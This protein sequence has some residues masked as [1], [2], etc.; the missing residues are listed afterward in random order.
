MTNENGARGAPPL[1]SAFRV[2]DIRMSQLFSIG[3]VVPFVVRMAPIALLLASDWRADMVVWLFW[4]ETA[5][6]GVGNAVRMVIGPADRIQSRSARAGLAVIFLVCYEGFVALTGLFCSGLFPGVTGLQIVNG[7]VLV[8]LGYA[9]SLA[10]VLLYG[11]EDRPIPISLLVVGPVTRAGA[12]YAIAFMG[13]MLAM[14]LGSPLPALIPLLVLEF[15]VEAFAFAYRRSPPGAGVDV[16][17]GFGR[18]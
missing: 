2:P 1:G 11:S 15:L 5:L 10:A 7:F 4:I 14:A 16:S 8:S 13:G 18:Q 12:L 17:T 6:F 9:V 3:F